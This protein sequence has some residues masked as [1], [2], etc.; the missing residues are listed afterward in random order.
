MSHHSIHLLRD[1]QENPMAARHSLHV[2]DCHCHVEDTRHSV[3]R[4]Q[5]RGE[6]VFERGE[7]AMVVDGERSVHAI[8]TKMDLIDFLAARA[9][10]G[11]FAKG[12]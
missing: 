10:L 7:V 11:G 2:H 6:C 12:A 5:L 8:V 4:A 3:V 1:L 9:R